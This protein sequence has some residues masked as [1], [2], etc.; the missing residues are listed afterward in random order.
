VTGEKCRVTQ[1]PLKKEAPATSYPHI[2]S[3]L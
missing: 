2:R 1:S 3:C